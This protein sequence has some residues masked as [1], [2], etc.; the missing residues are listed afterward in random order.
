MKFLNLTPHTLTIDTIGVL[1]PTGILPRCATVRGVPRYVGGVRVI[2][3]TVGAV[4]G[5]PYAVEGINL[6]V[7]GMVLAALDG[8][9]PDVFA[10]DTGPDAV[11]VNGQIVSVL[12][13]VQ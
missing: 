3:Q 1:E 5:L 6:I 10:P 9:R 12:G 11:R 8:S 7:S 2:E 13:L 4:T